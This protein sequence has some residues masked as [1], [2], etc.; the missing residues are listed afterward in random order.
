MRLF[1]LPPHPQLHLLQILFPA[2]SF[3]ILGANIPCYLLCSRSRL[4]FGQDVVP[5]VLFHEIVTDAAGVLIMI[6]VLHSEVSSKASLLRFAF[7][8]PR[9]MEQPLGPLP[10]SVFSGESS[11]W[12]ETSIAGELNLTAKEVPKVCELT[13]ELNVYI[14]CESGAIVHVRLDPLHEA[15]DFTESTIKESGPLLS[16]LRGFLPLGGKKQIPGVAGLAVHGPLL[17][18]LY[19]D[20]KLRVW[21]SVRGNA[22]VLSLTVPTESW[23]PE[24]PTHTSKWG[25]RILSS[26]EDDGDAFETSDSRMRASRYFKLGIYLGLTGDSQVQVYDGAYDPETGNTS[27]VMEGVSFYGNDRFIDFAIS[28]GQSLSI[29]EDTRHPRV[30]GLWQGMQPEDGDYV[31]AHA[32]LARSK[33]S[34]VLEVNNWTEAKLESPSTGL[35]SLVSPNPSTHPNLSESFLRHIFQPGRFSHS[36]ITRALQVFA[37]TLITVNQPSSARELKAIVATELRR[38]ILVRTQA[39]QDRQS[40][41]SSAIPSRSGSPHRFSNGASSSSHAAKSASNWRIAHSTWTQFLEVCI[42]VWKSEHTPLALFCVPGTYGLV[43]V[44]KAGQISAL[45]ETTMIESLSLLTPRSRATFQQA[46]LSTFLPRSSSAAP[47]RAALPGAR[48]PALRSPTTQSNSHASEIFK[49]LDL[50]ST[51]TAQIGSAKLEIFEQRLFNLTDPVAS[52]TVDVEYLFGSPLD[53]QSA[54]GDFQDDYSSSEDRIARRSFINRFVRA[55]R[56]VSNIGYSL[57]LLLT[58]VIQS[59]HGNTSKS[60]ADRIYPKLDASVFSDFSPD[61]EVVSDVIARGFQQAIATNFDLLRDMLYLALLCIRSEL[62]LNLDSSV[63]TSLHSLLPKIARQLKAHHVLKWISMQ[64]VSGNPMEAALGAAT[65][66]RAG[67]ATPID[68]F[69]L[70]RRLA[71]GPVSAVH[72][73]LMDAWDNICRTQE[74]SRAWRSVSSFVS[75]LIR[76]VHPDTVSN[77]SCSFANQ[78]LVRG[79]HLS[80]FEYI[81][82]LDSKTAYHRDLMGDCYLALGQYEKALECFIQASVN[83]DKEAVVDLYSASQRNPLALSTRETLGRDRAENESYGLYYWK[84]LLPDLVAQQ[85]HDL[86]IRSA[87]CALSSTDISDESTFSLLYSYIFTSALA[88]DHH[89]EAYAAL[90]H[91][92][93]DGKRMAALTEFVLAFIERG[94]AKELAELPFVN[95]L[96]QV[97]SLIIQRAKSSDIT[98]PGPTLYHVLYGFHIAKSNY[99]L[100]AEAIFIYAERIVAEQH[101]GLAALERYSAALLAALSALKLLD[102]SHAY[103]VSRRLFVPASP[104]KRPRDE[105][106]AGLGSLQLESAASRSVEVHDIPKLEL[107]YLISQCNLALVRLDKSLAPSGVKSAPA[108]LMLLVSFDQFD[109]AFEVA[110]KA[111]LPMDAIF[112]RQ[113]LYCLR[114]PVGKVAWASL[115]SNLSKHDS[116]ATNLHYHFVVADTILSTDRSIALPVWLVLS[117]KSGIALPLESS[118]SSPA[119]QAPT[120]PSDTKDKSVQLLMLYIKHNLLEE[121]AKLSN[122]II[123]RATRRLEAPPTDAELVQ[124]ALPYTYIEQ[125]L[126]ELQN[127]ATP[128]SQLHS[129][130]ASSLKAYLDVAVDQSN[131]LL[132]LQE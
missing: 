88:I 7:P 76:F 115:R 131:Q 126:H 28:P 65:S 21:S 78:L 68:E 45:R 16:A 85:L 66:R 35:D 121:A 89:E 5:N 64:W 62:Q 38:E 44:I 58:L 104:H 86:V 102:P 105:L 47:Q 97:H 42:Q 63:L 132:D 128:N 56:S 19:E 31:L 95:M 27:L 80:L 77:D 48:R 53:N 93:D 99:R 123:L 18:A 75:S 6:V 29:D 10:M 61:S 67:P 108:T 84:A 20:A 25:L 114:Q 49:T 92:N 17:F 40:V 59:I 32:Q 41:N 110:D 107:L 36:I 46:L 94:K 109:L 79:Q 22:L 100:A 60:Q 82:L 39:H 124:S 130:V 34:Q 125:V 70:R 72:L 37:K 87:S 2:L 98:L 112:T 14:G 73:Y 57:E 69:V 91:I 116:A 111:K 15:N 129:K 30:W 1:P 90:I 83:L 113:T 81:R 11:D 118:A 119:D 9:F 52:A 26:S 127:S 8:H 74:D 4:V 50:M 96:D 24:A 12:L 120:V 54:S 71:I 33:S 103:L 117:F 55:A 43:L 106:A 13:D 101:L 51:I 122:E 3:A 23:N